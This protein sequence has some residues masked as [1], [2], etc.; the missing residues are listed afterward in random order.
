[1][2]MHTGI[3]FLGVTCN[4]RETGLTLN[5]M[6]RSCS[7]RISDIFFDNVQMLHECD[8]LNLLCVSLATDIK[9]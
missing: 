4:L 2:S 7:I 6:Q 5:D 9:L 8:S 3:C 1:M